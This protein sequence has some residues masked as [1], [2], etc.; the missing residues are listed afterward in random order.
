MNESAYRIFI[1]MSVKVLACIVTTIQM[2]LTSS[3]VWSQF[4]SNGLGSAA[5]VLQV[6][7]CKVWTGLLAWGFIVIACD[8]VDAVAK[9]TLVM[10]SH[11]SATQVWRKAFESIP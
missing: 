9:A 1:L 10:S 11:V 4:L 2:A 5:L 8:T 3:L 6:R 7:L